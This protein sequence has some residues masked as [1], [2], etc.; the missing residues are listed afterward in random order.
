[1]ACPYEASP[2]CHYN[3]KR[4][5]VKI[6]I[7]QTAFIGDVVLATP[8]I[9]G[10]LRQYPDA[11]VKFLTI[12]YSAPVLKNY[13]GLSEVLVLDK[14]G[15]DKWANTFRMIKRLREER[16]DL[17]VVPHRSLRSASMVFLAGIPERIGFDKSAGKLLLTKT[18]EYMRDWHEVKRNLSLLRLQDENIPPRI[19]PGID[20]ENRADEFLRRNNV[21]HRFICIAPGS[22][23]ETKKWPEEHF[24]QL[25]IQMKAKGYPQVVL[26]GGGKEIDIC[27]RVA[28]GLE[29]YVNIAAGELN[30]LESGALLKRASLL[31]AND[32]AAGHIAAAVGT[33]IISIFGPTVPAFGFAPYGEGNIIVEHP[34]L[35]CR[36]CRIHGSKKCPEGHFRC[37]KEVAAE[38]VLNTVM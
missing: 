1:M 35:Y 24:R 29:G 14:R 5:K 22:I 23:W 21:N 31:I 16:F 33:K 34:D 32:S 6:L 28:A 25:C 17:A 12:P 8:L 37:M 27:N 2:F 10:A 7:L 18:I 20:E 11:E 3:D 15:K 38:D 36:P 30:P 9:E 13:P 26:I 4:L 19:Y